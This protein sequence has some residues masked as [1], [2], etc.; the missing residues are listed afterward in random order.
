VKKEQRAQKKALRTSI[1]TIRN[2]GDSQLA[3]V[4]GGATQSNNGCG[5]LTNAP[6]VCNIC[7]R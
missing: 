3:E 2:L 4:A 5:S 1:E 6:S 7:Q